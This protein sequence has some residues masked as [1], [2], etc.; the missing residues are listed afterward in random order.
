MSWQSL[1][2]LAATL[3]SI[4]SLTCLA[5]KEY[6]SGNPRTLSELA[7]KNKGT[8]TYFRTVLWLCG[9]LFALALF[10]S[11]TYF[12]N[13]M[14]IILGSTLMIG[15]ELLLAWLPA[16]SKTMRAHNILAIV[17]AIGMLILA[18][19]FIAELTDVYRLV[20]IIIGAS[21][22]LLALLTFVDRKHF[23]FYEL[24]FIFLSHL[25]IVIALFAIV[26]P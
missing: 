25:S 7:A 21:M 26:K 1:V 13:R 17:M 2:A 23:V 5:W 8:L 14:L 18:V 4:P 20:A 12:D 19:T 9:S 3:I 22:G 6:D 24:P 10:P 16:R 15:G 11:A